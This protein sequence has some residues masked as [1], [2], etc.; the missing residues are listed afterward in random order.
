[1]EEL[2]AKR[3]VQALLSIADKD[4]RKVYIKSLNHDD[5]STYHFQ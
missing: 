4:E 2:I 1:M 5:Q 3:Y